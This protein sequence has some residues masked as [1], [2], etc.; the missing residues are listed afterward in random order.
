MM[1]RV[2]GFTL[3]EMVAV[4]LLMALLAVAATLSLTG[5]FRQV[6]MKEVI[7]Q[8]ARQ[9]QL[10]RQQS[11]QSGQPMHLVLNLSD[12]WARRQDTQ[13][14]KSAQPWSLPA[15]YR[16]LKIFLLGQETNQGEVAIPYSPKGL[17]PSYI[18]WLSGP[19]EQQRQILV[20]GLTGQVLEVG[21]ERQLKILCSALK[22][23]GYDPA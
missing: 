18:L 8:L 5:R 19:N 23:Q 1:P 14:V 20:T 7:D 2:R 6:A 13:E 12:G 10:V 15:G 9:D 22:M 16:V 17:S 3:I 4:V 11:R 21:D